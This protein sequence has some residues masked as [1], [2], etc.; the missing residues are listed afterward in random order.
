MPSFYRQKRQSPS[1]TRCQCKVLLRASLAQVPPVFVLCGASLP[2]VWPDRS[3]S[4]SSD[5]PTCTS[6]I[7]ASRKH[8]ST[9]QCT[10]DRTSTPNALG[11]VSCTRAHCSILDSIL[12]SI[13]V[14]HAPLDCA[15]IRNPTLP[16]AQSR[17]QLHPTLHTTCSYGV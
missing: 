5:C 4:S 16:N 3:S 11:H 2:S 17:E 9:R 10:I 8:H 1:A 6:A 14:Q 7:T 13:L 12:D 15:S